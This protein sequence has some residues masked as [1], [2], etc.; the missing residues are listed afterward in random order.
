[1][2]SITAVFIQAFLGSYIIEVSLVKF[3]CQF[4]GSQSHSM[5]PGPLALL[6]LSLDVSWS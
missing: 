4:Y 3:V 5:F 6:H 1:M 2:V